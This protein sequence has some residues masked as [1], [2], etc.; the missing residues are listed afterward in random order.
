MKYYI[1]YKYYFLK[2]KQENYNTSI[3]ILFNIIIIIMK[4]CQH[5]SPRHSLPTR[6]YRPSLPVGPKGY[7][8]YQHRAAVC[9]F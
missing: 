3:F 9:R 8:L 2:E 5:G 4:R 6:L 1:V 7:I